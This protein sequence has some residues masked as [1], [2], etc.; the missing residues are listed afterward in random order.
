MSSSEST[1][2]SKEEEEESMQG[3]AQA[4]TKAGVSTVGLA[5]DEAA[6]IEACYEADVEKMEKCIEDGV[7]VNVS[8]VN[9]RTALHFCAGNGLPTLCQKLLDAGAELN[10]QDLMGLTPLHM[11][12]GYK[13]LETVKFLIDAQADANIA[14]FEGMLPVEIAE[15]LLEKTPRKK[16]FMANEEHKRLTEI[17]DLLDEATEEEED[18]DEDDSEEKKNDG[19]DEYGEMREET[20]SA[21]FVVRVKPKSEKDSTTRA[22]PVKVDDVKV[23]I[24]VKEPENKK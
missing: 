5:A 17:V 1:E 9:K 4:P 2:E 6:F 12:S 11:A 8:D 13:K 14:T 7:D 21:K 24:R 23:T 15:N 3:P 19:F 10:M 20:E 16:F 18:E 22:E